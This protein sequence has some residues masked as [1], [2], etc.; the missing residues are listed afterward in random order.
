MASLLEMSLV[1][2]CHVMT[3]MDETVKKV[4]GPWALGLECE[5]MSLF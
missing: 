3:Y 5:A 1:T 2:T 4:I